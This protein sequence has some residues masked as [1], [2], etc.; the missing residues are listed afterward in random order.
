MEEEDETEL[1]F[2]SILADIATAI[3]TVPILILEKLQELLN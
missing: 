3:I 2:L 1:S